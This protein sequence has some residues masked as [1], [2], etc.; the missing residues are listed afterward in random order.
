MC[1]YPRVADRDVGLNCYE[2]HAISNCYD[3]KMCLAAH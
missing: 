3:R 1:G 2:R